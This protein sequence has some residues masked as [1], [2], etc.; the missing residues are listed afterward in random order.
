MLKKV[1]N[2]ILSLLL[3]LS[4]TTILA[5]Y[6]LKNFLSSSNIEKML[7]TDN[8][9]IIENSLPDF[10]DYIDQKE[11]NKV[12][13]NLL[14]NYLQYNIGLLKQTPS[15]DELTNILNKYCD[16]YEQA[17]DIKID[18][19]FINTNIEAL[20]K[21]L[22]ENMQLKKDH[23]TVIFYLLNLDSTPIIAIIAF[24]VILIIYFL[25]NRNILKLI[26]DLAYIFIM[27][28]VGMY[29]LGIVLKYKLKAEIAEYEI[30]ANVVN[31]LQNILNHVA[32]YSFIIGIILLAIY[33][34][35]KLIKNKKTR[36]NY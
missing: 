7:F 13:S 34:V 18:R 19:S 12:Y 24:I 17:K 8:N 27:D 9:V 30:V 22:K 35:I 4:L 23:M 36:Y 5:S 1:I 31:Y 16:S 32:I 15:L 21:N 28:T 10:N 11:L 26:S 2:Y 33:L 6:I 25:I 29:A 3:L 20:D 14:S